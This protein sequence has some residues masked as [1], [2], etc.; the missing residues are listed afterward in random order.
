MPEA[1]CD[2]SKL[3]R[4]DSDV[5]RCLVMHANSDNIVL[6]EHSRLRVA[7]RQDAEVLVA[8]MQF[9]KGGNHG[10]AKQRL[11]WPA[12]GTLRSEASAGRRAGRRST[13]LDLVSKWA[14]EIGGAVTSQGPGGQTSRA[15]S[16]LWMDGAPRIPA[17][18]ATRW[19]EFGLD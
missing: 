18:V 5:A 15:P 13:G 10:T 11:S 16:T 8:N 4:V 19:V 9:P 3:F 1:D 2:A 17:P 6:V 12:L 14:G 7:A